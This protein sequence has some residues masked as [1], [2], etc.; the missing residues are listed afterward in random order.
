MKKILA[1][2][3]IAISTL[4]GCATTGNVVL[5]NQ[6]NLA[7]AS[8]VF[9]DGSNTVKGSAL[10]RQ[11]GGGVVTCAGN[12]VSLIAST[13]YSN[14]RMLALYRNTEKGYRPIQLSFAKTFFAN[15]NLEYQKTIRNTTCDAQGFFKYEKVPDGDYFV[16]TTITWKS[17][18]YS[19]EGGSLMQKVRVKSGEIKE[20]VLASS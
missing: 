14:E 19:F 6:F 12:E 7:E 2:S 9:K 18:A 17:S 4:T 3:V 5:V 16:V 13:S 20:I 1:Y 10:L 8:I 11:A 15:E